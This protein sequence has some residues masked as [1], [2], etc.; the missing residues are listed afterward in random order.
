MK[1]RKIL[2]LACVLGAAHITACSE[3]DS[4]STGASGSGVCG[5]GS[6]NK[7]ED[8]DDGNTVS[9][10]GCSETCQVEIGYVCPS[11]KNCRL[12]D[13]SETCGNGIV[14]E[15]EAC[16]DGNTVSGDGCLGNCMSVET[17][18][19]CK[20]AGKKCEKAAYCGNGKVD[21]GEECDDANK[22]SGDGCSIICTVEAGWKCPNN[23]CVEEDDV[24]DSFCGDGILDEGED[25]D[26]H[27]TVSGD[28]CSST[29]TVESGW[30]CNATGCSEIVQEGYCG[31]GEVNNG[32]ECD[33]GEAFSGDGCSSDCKVEP[34]YHCI[35]DG[36]FSVCSLGVCGDGY[37]DTGLGEEC[38]DPSAS[39]SYA[40]DP[41][42]C[43]SDCKAAPYCGDGNIDT[44][45]GADGGVY[46][47]E[48][49]DGEL[50][51]TSDKGCSESCL[52]NSY[53]GDGKV[54]RSAG[55]ICDEG[56]DNGKACLDC[57]QV[58]T[59][60]RCSALGANEGGTGCME[61]TCGNG[62]QDIGE[63]C[64]EGGYVNSAGCVNCQVSAGYKCNGFGNGSCTPINYGDGKI[65][66]GIKYVAV[67]DKNGN[68]TMQAEK[69]DYEQCDDG[70]RKNG[71][72]CDSI[73][74]IEAGYKCSGQPS[75]CT[76]VCGDGLKL[77]AE[78]CDDGNTKAGDGCSPA[79]V[80]EYGFACSETSGKSKCSTGKC[81]DGKV[82]KGEQCDDG[83]TKAGDGCSASCTVEPM[84]E[85]P[86]KG[87]KCIKRGCGDKKITPTAG[88][89]NAE[90][91]DGVTGCGSD[92]RPAA[93]YACNAAGTKCTSGTCGD[94]IVQTGEQ[95]DDGN[96]GGGDGCSPDCKIEAYFVCDNTDPGQ[97][98]D[99]HAQCGD[100][101][102]M[103]ML[104]G[105]KAEEC[106]DGNTLDGDGCSSTCK[107]EPG[108]SCT[109]Y[110]KTPNTVSL[111]VTYRDF[112]GRD[113]Y[114]TSGGS[115][116]Q[117]TAWINSLGATCK[118]NIQSD[119]TLAG[120]LFSQSKATANNA[121]YFDN[122][123]SYLKANAGHPDFQGFSG[124]V[125]QG[126]AAKTLGADGKPKYSGK[127]LDAKCTI[128]NNSGKSNSFGAISAT[129]SYRNYTIGRH[130]LCGDSFE[131]W[132][133]DTAM[134][135]KVEGTL[136]LA[137]QSDGVYVFDSDNP[138]SAAKTVA[139]LNYIPGYFSPID[140]MG[141]KDTRPNTSASPIGCSAASST[142]V[143][144]P[145]ACTPRKVNG[146]FTT[147]IHTYFQY[148]GGE[149]LTFSGDDD[150]WIYI[151]NQLFVDLGGLHSRQEMTN[152][153][154]K[155]TCTYKDNITGTTKTQKCD[156]TFNLYE[157]GIYDIHM[158]QAEREYTGSNFKLTLDGF[159][160]TG[161][162]SCASVCGDGI[163]AADEECDFGSPTTGSYAEFMGCVNCKRTNNVAA[164]CGNGKLDQG[165]QCDTG[166][167]CKNSAYTSYCNKIGTKYTADSEC[168]EK[169]CKYADGSVCGNGKKEGREQCDDG[170]TKSND[171]CSATCLIE[172]CGDGIVNGNEECDDG[173]TVDND[174]CSSKCTLPSCGDGLVTADE[175]C[176][177]GPNNGKYG[178]CM[179]GC[180]GYAPY[181][182]DGTVQKAEG[183][184]CD[185]G[186]GNND[187]A[188]NG[189]KK[190]C[191]L[192]F[193][194]GDGIV[195]SGFEDCDPCEGKGP[196]CDMNASATCTPNCTLRS[197]L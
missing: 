18:W 115:G 29:C 28:G 117:T 147:E 142:A 100:G 138:P 173:N 113:T 114:N 196:G 92:C 179:V 162:T 67:L 65:D 86:V 24:E 76:T 193:H 182:G 49:D 40:K 83:N 130:I 26:D 84:Y 25:C 42:A 118:R 123:V 8:C 149:S 165:E 41:G 1:L 17:G 2:A 4:V 178:Y 111:P 156:K 158:F 90:L 195:S 7:G 97:L 169:T 186:S 48:C 107:K 47:E 108:F 170:N 27:N 22:K 12:S 66:T 102:T 137:K 63:Q 59:G 5:D 68:I 171:G 168:N 103:W 71:D 183:E 119:T 72:G 148:K 104:A 132:F 110:T 160:N 122:G 126:I 99:C 91:C 151:N 75:V 177:D 16:D 93:G 150:V 140:N 23:V 192:G 51:G 191:K 141:F 159:L 116:Y 161:V 187:T 135:N 180:Q 15:D 87:G 157:G 36:G 20:E 105:N 188:Y 125:C 57:K 189:C 58:K 127:S 154:A 78:E 120:W 144:N 31:D 81:G 185:L 172:K 21:P 13:P 94:G 134:S 153:L 70:N 33:D 121:S 14:D 74:Q 197:I 11:G 56:K 184:E 62:R 163:V 166:Y 82:Q 46:K 136:L 194:C 73:G 32:E 89:N 19:V 133:R 155:D 139:G 109:L 79:C 45:V 34:N 77:G 53:C 106:D 6:W 124:N 181:C 60:W 112:R 190:N 129:S 164:A 174:Y 54:D 3:D 30:I 69:V 96:L 50:N 10:D 55:E 37:V 95:C 44:Y 167:L 146:N 128:D 88:Y 131:T 35:N 9:G 85:C 64:D 152:T 52:L 43:T 80:V 98:S 143:S 176:D 101:V 38:D 175:L 61:I 145:K 39:V